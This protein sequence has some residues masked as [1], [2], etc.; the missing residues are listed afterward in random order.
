MAYRKRIVYLRTEFCVLCVLMLVLFF[1]PKLPLGGFYD[2]LVAVLLTVPMLIGLSEKKYNKTEM[3]ILYA[4]LLVCVLGVISNFAAGI[5]TSVGYIANDAF[6]FVRI[7]V[8]Y[9][10][11]IALLRGKQKA[12][13][14][15]ITKLGL[16]SKVFITVAF[17]C[18]LFNLAGILRMYSTIRYGLRNYFFFFG[19]ASQ[20][21]IYA[22]CALAFLVYS[23]K[24]KPIY[25]L[26]ALACLVMTFK[27]MGL[28]IAAVYSILIYVVHRKLKWWHYVLAMPVLVFILQFQIN[29]YILDESAPRAM[30][31]RYG[32]VTA[33]HFFPFGAGFAAY[34]S[35]MAAVHYSPLY[36]EYG[37]HLRKALTVFSDGD[38]T[39]TTFLNDAY[40]GMVAGQFGII[41]LIIVAYVFIKL[42]ERIFSKTIALSKSKSITIACFCCFCGMAIMAGSIKTAGGE[43][44]M[45]VFAVYQL[46]TESNK[47]ADVATEMIV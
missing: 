10:G 2:D 32:F 8:V 47:T 14:S 35:N 44:L 36:Y 39:T 45:V 15:L 1:V 19:N 16:Y 12:L 40:L 21:G 13:D 41:G 28:I 18:G 26:M 33:M 23:N 4:L 11:V 46:L 29:S 38:G 6:S 7:F 24:S 22:G 9:F 17:V 34:G 30:L 31:I 20:F 3:S 43:L 37:F 27:G 42:G 5:V 25:E